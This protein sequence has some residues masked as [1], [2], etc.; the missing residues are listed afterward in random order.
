M[1]EFLRITGLACLLALSSTAWSADGDP[2]NIYGVYLS[3]RAE[4]PCGRSTSF[5]RNA[6]CPVNEAGIAAKLAAD[7]DPLSDPGLQC[8]PAR[9]VRL[10]TWFPRPVEFIRGDDEI[11]L[12]YENMGVVRTV[13]MNDMPA[14][15][16]EWKSL[17]GFSRGHWDDDTLVVETTNLM[18]NPFVIPTSDQTRTIERYRWND[19]RSRLLLDVEV[20]DPGYYDHSFKLLPAEFEP[21]PNGFIGDY[22]CTVQTEELFYGDMD[23]FFDE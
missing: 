4:T 6:D 18:E 3:G 5:D 19:D 8:E 16:A 1:T 20:I 15:P 21:Q 22:E 9:L 12:R 14:P 11:V 17:H 23:S 7:A 2:R 10:F 13:H